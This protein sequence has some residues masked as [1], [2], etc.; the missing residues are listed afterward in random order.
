MK[1]ARVE[2]QQS[3]GSQHLPFRLHGKL[4]VCLILLPLFLLLTSQLPPC[5]TTGR[6][7]EITLGRVECPSL[8]FLVVKEEYSFSLC[9]FVKSGHLK[10]ENSLV[11]NYVTLSFNG[12]FSF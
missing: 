8:R 4:M 6:S 2:R 7:A 11:E 10:R 3:R 5:A 1:K 9:N 12:F